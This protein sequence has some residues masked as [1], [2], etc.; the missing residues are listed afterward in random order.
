MSGIFKVLNRF[1]SVCTENLIQKFVRLTAA[2]ILGK[3]KY[4]YVFM[5]SNATIIVRKKCSR[6]G[7]QI[8]LSTNLANFAGSFRVSLFTERGVQNI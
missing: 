7:L 1:N 5:Q 2:V 3:K 8:L 6:N 4:E